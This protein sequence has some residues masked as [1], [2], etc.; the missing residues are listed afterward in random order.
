MN[1]ISILLAGFV[2]AT[3]VWSQNATSHSEDLVARSRNSIDSAIDQAR[4]MQQQITAGPTRQ[5]LNPEQ[6]RNMKGVDPSSLAEKYNSALK[7]SPKHSEELMI[8]ISTSMPTKALR[9][10]GQQ[11]VASGAVLILRGMKGPLGTKGVMEETAKALQPVAE[12]G[13]AI[14][15]DPESFT[16]FNITA[17]PTFVIAP[18]SESCSSTQCETKAYALVGDVSLQYALEYWSQRGGEAG[19][20]ADQYLRRMRLD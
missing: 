15:I 2:F 8:F 7:A 1:K 9:L 6:L 16:K 13:A 3:N 5:G 18:R 19:Q 14:Q 12:T 4:L 10:L 20:K 17:V 11:A